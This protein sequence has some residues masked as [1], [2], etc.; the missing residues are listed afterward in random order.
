MLQPVITPTTSTSIP[1]AGL[2]A[3]RPVQ[4]TQQSSA[5]RNL[6]ANAVRQNSE[7]EEAGAD[8]EE[9]RTQ[10]VDGQR[11]AGSFARSGGFN[12]RGENLDILV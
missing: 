9:D 5:V 7:S 6:T 2:I 8:S 3:P 1:S 4:Q 11:V 12:G 10:R